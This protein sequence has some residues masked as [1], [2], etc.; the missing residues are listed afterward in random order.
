MEAE[1]V[2]WEVFHIVGPRPG[3]PTCPPVLRILAPLPTPVPVWGGMVP[4]DLHISSPHPAAGVRPHPAPASGHSGSV[5]RPPDD[6]RLPERGHERRGQA[7][8]AAPVAETRDLDE[9]LPQPGGVA[10]TQACL[11]PVP[12]EGTWEL[13]LL[14]DTSNL[15]SS[16]QATLVWCL[17]C[18]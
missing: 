3:C 18:G 13:L 6:C 8:P 2:W 9:S 17:N 4:R 15:C 10:P 16:R 7:S 14:Q 1:S 11:P 5:S 12:A